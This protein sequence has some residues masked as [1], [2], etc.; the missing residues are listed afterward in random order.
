MGERRLWKY[1]QLLQC[2]CC[3]LSRHLWA[4]FGVS[5]LMIFSIKED[6]DTAAAA[7]HY[8]SPCSDHRWR[9]LCLS[10]SS[11]LPHLPIIEWMQWTLFKVHDEASNKKALVLFDCSLLLSLSLSTAAFTFHSLFSKTPISLTHSLSLQVCL[12]F[13]FHFSLSA[14]L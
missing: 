10:S 14:S 9:M 2:W 1:P 13:F 5:M 6:A 8:L 11:T 4:L 12:N 7:Q 3:S